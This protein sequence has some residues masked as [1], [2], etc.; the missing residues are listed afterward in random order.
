MGLVIVSLLLT[1]LFPSLKKI[2]VSIT[3]GKPAVVFLGQN[4]NSSK[5]IT[6]TDNQSQTLYEIAKDDISTT[7]SSFNTLLSL[8]LV[9]LAI[10]GIGFSLVTV[11]TNDKIKY[12]D[13]LLKDVTNK[14]NLLEDQ[15]SSIGIQATQ[16]AQPPPA[17]ATVS[18]NNPDATQSQAEGPVPTAI[19]T[20]DQTD[21]SG[22]AMMIAKM[23]L[24]ERTYRL[25]FGSQLI[26]LKNLYAIPAHSMTEAVLQ[27]IHRRS[28]YADIPF[29][30]YIGFLT[31]NLLIGKNEEN[32]SYFL[33]QLGTEFINY[34]IQNAMPDKVE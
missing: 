22:E 7:N 13:L 18:S 3:Y 20:P 5:N 25:I 9:M 6:F 32:N 17:A 16:G 14:K 2:N 23:A 10:L 29:T 12:I 33:T 24:F 28:K 8:V 15:L 30:D 1:L 31:S 34:L 19:A 27:A 26:I 4:S 21:Q 11:V